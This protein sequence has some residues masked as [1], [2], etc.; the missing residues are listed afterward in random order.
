MAQAY[1]YTPP[2]AAAPV[3]PHFCLARPRSGEI[4]FLSLHIAP[5]LS[6]APRA[7]RTLLDIARGFSVI[8]LFI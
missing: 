1:Y 7:T 5:A 8:G 4:P 2:V 3:L 6:R